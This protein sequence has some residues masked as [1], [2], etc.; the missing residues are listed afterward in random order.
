VMFA[1]PR[2]SGWIAQWSEMLQDDETKI[3]R[4]RQIYT[5]ERER[6]YVPLSER[7]QLT[8]KPMSETKLID[9][10]QG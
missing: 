3:A 6:D 10:A 7:T 9:P 8:D 2:T 5:G 4:P 1:I